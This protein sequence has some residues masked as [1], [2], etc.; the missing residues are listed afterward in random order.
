MADFDI[1]KPWVILISGTSESV[2]SVAL[3][4]AAYIEILR[5]GFRIKQKSLSILNSKDPSAINYM[6]QSPHIVLR[7]GEGKENGFSWRMDKFRLEIIGESGR[8]L[9]NGMFDFLSAL[10]FK[11]KTPGSEELPRRN[12]FAPHILP[13]QTA[14]NHYNGQKRYLLFSAN[15][16]K[17]ESWILWAARNRIDALVFP[18]GS[19]AFR[20]FFKELIQRTQRYEIDVEAGGWELPLLVPR[21]YFFFHKGMFRMN[22]G[23]RDKKVNFCPTSPETIRI[24][25]QEARKVFLAHPYTRVFHFWPTRGHEHEWCSC[26]T[27][28]AFTA[29]EQN[30]IA[31]NVAADVLQRV[32]PSAVISYCELSNEESSIDLRDNVVKMSRLFDT[33]GQETSGWFFAHPKGV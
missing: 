19:K 21:K 10:G 20:V 8:G 11:W 9:F 25:S 31:I 3:E 1:L 24:I 33:F 2:N 14:E 7:A 22:E 5:A 32:L 27:C 6:G 4:L 12:S 26:P 17:V 13:M 23:K 28:R 29:E 16:K 15:Q 30:R 18:L